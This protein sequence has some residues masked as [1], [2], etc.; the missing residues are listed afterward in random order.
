[1]S[2]VY[3]PAPDKPSYRIIVYSSDEAMPHQRH[4][5]YIALPAKTAKGQSDEHFISVRFPAT[6]PGT[7]RSAAE[8][9]WQAE[10]ERERA[11]TAAS[12]KRGLALEAFRASRRA[13]NSEPSNV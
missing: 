1:M 2:E 10:I 12:E 5:A 13:A 3:V 11:K 6:D 4:V 8:A 9:Y 7:A